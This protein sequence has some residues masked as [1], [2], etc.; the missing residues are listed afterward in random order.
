MCGGKKKKMYYNNNKR[1]STYA[2]NYFIR[3]AYK[4]IANNRMFNNTVAGTKQ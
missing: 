3:N 2:R 4:I 1:I